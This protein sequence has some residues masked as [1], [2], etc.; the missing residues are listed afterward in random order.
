MTAL[1]TPRR[2]EV[3]EA[4]AAYRAAQP[5]PSGRGLER[6]DG[7]DGGGARSAIRRSPQ[8]SSA[9]RSCGRSRA[10][11]R[12]WCARPSCSRCAAGGRSTSGTQ[13]CSTRSLRTSRVIRATRRSATRR[14]TALRDRWPSRRGDRVPAGQRASTTGAT[15]PAA[16]AYF[17]AALVADPAF[18]LAASSRGGCPG[19]RRAG[20]TRRGRRSRPRCR[21]HAARPSRSGTS[22]RARRAARPV[23]GR[24]VPRAHVAEPGPFGLV[25]VRLPGARPRRRGEERVHG[26]HGSRAEVGA[27]RGRP[28]VEDRA[29]RPGA[30]R[31]DGRAAR[32]RRAAAT[33][34]AEDACQ[35]AGGAGARRVAGAARAHRRGERAG[36]A[37]GRRWP[38]STWRAS[39]AWAPSHRVDDVVASFSDAAPQML[40]VL[41]RAGTITAGAAR[42]P[43]GRLARGVAREDERRLSRDSSGSPAGRPRTTRAE[44]AARRSSA[45]PSFG[46]LPPFAPNS[47]TAVAVGR[48]YLLAGQH[49]RRRR[50]SA[51]R[52]HGELHA[53]LRPRSATTHGWL[54]LGAALE[55]AEGRP[56]GR[57][58]RVPRGA[59]AAGKKP[60]RDRSPRSAPA[61]A[62]PLS[63]AADR[64]TQPPRVGRRVT[65]RGDVRNSRTGGR[66]SCGRRMLEAARNGSKG[67]LRAPALL[68]RSWE[69]GTGQDE[70]PKRRVDSGRGGSRAPPPL[71]PSQSLAQTPMST[72]DAEIP[73]AQARRSRRRRPEVCDPCV[74][75]RHG[76]GRGR[77][78]PRRRAVLACARS[79]R[80]TPR[81][82]PGA[83]E[84]APTGRCCLGTP[85]P[86]PL[87]HRPVRMA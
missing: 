67:A 46:G 47:A 62:R 56:R 26:P 3:P 36:R 71:A 8:R 24:G 9:W 49:G 14:L 64:G 48:V 7:L 5:E 83:A 68:L 20:A 82:G 57:L 28:P 35:R 1:P 4:L 66:F 69:R 73:R 74:P 59:R 31:R 37:R 34:A 87:L 55:R 75:H 44:E 58:R 63:P 51:W 61:S 41:A 32:R 53:A 2:P 65:R 39:E 17:D 27:A 12:A 40:G 13:R 21:T 23:R 80:S 78:L 85:A 19:V 10:S 52:G 70:T 22:P 77:V 29:A 33:G 15:L 50:N 45:L 86:P 25:R 43:P 54:D 30:R 6:R 16:L 42:P 11:T 79:A 38:T 81:A 84:F 72:S 76:R 60:S 18:A